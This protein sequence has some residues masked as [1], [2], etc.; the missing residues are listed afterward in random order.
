[1]GVNDKQRKFCRAVAREEAH[2]GV[3]QRNDVWICNVAGVDQERFRR[4]HEQIHER[5]FESGAKILSKNKCSGIVRMLLE[6]GLR[7]LGAIC[8]TFVPVNVH[9]SRHE[10]SFC[11]RGRKRNCESQQG[12]KCNAAR[13][14]GQ[15]LRGGQARVF[16]VD[17]AVGSACHGYKA[18]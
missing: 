11:R 12:E 6:S 17:D 5:R 13:P 14:G 4:S 1:M 15:A 16:F 8:R 10:L 2:H 9:R 3:C 18:S 7:I